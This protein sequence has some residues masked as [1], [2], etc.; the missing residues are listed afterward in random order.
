VSI[1]DQTATGRGLAGIVLAAGASQRLG[2]PKQLVEWNGVPLI[3][4]TVVAMRRHC[5]LGVSCILGAHAEEIRAALDGHDVRII[6]NTDWCE[7]IA[8]SIRAGI[9]SVPADA[10]AVLL[11]VCDQPL[12]S[13]LDYARLVTHWRDDP[14]A[15]T[16]AGYGDDYGVPAIFPVA[17]RGELAELRGDRGAKSVIDCTSRRQIVAMPDAAFDIDDKDDLQRLRELDEP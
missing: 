11:T 13:D 16:V 7:G 17:Y 1:K 6:I 2:R 9:E 4:R 12:V 8:T 10:Q 15:I 3:V 14:A 5:N